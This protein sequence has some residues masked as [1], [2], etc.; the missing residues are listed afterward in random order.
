MN[1]ACVLSILFAQEKEQKPNSKQF[2][3]SMTVDFSSKRKTR[4]C[5]TTFGQKQFQDFS[6]SESQQ[7]GIKW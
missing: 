1:K 5:A 2:F 3:C 6:P 4:N 7:K